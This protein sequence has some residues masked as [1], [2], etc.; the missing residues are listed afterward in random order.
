MQVE[1][2]WVNVN[3]AQSFKTVFLGDSSVGK[4]CMAK[5]FVNREVES[6]TA[7]TIGFDHHVKDLELDEDVT[8]KVSHIFTAQERV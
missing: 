8:V 1:S 7:N 3:K 2:N 5:L 4:T 6:G